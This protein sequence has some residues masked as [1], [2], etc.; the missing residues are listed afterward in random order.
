MQRT[1][2][3]LV[4]VCGFCRYFIVLEGM[5]KLMSSHFLVR[6]LLTFSIIYIHTE[7]YTA[8]YVGI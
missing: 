7:L 8:F 3:V 2:A 4:M 6:G 1:S 5:R